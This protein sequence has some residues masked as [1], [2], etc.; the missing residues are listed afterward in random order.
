VGYVSN[1]PS[2]P[3]GTFP[4]CQNSRG[5]LETVPHHVRWTFRLKLRPSASGPVVGIATALPVG[6]ILESL[7][8]RICAPCAH[9]RRTD[10]WSVATDQRSVLR[11]GCGFAALGSVQKEAERERNRPITPWGGRGRAERAPGKA[12]PCGLTSFDRHPTFDHSHPTHQPSVTQ[13]VSRGLRQS[14]GRA[15]STG[16][17]DFQHPC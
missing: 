4:T 3:W 1:V 11:F 15:N 12:W 17:E 2:L 10:L 5:T 8:V 7:C 14:P 16:Q 6:M 9:V 13:G